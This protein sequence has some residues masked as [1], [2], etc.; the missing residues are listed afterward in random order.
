MATSAIRKKPEPIII[1][2]SNDIPEQLPGKVEKQASALTEK[3]DGPQ[4]TVESRPVAMKS[5]KAM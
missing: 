2:Q 4:I 1:D 3:H 5:A